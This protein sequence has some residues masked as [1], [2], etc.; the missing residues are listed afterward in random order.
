MPFEIQADAQ[1]IRTIFTGK[2]TETE[3]D[4]LAREIARIEGEYKIGP[5]RLVDFSAIEKSEV[6]S[7]SIEQ[8]AKAGRERVYPNKFRSAIVAQRLVD[9]GCARMYQT[10]NDNPQ[11]E[12][13]VFKTRAEAEAWLAGGAQ[14][15]FNHG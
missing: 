2:V 8:R 14:K 4:D 9:Y 11:I 1:T 7:A 12:I 15:N 10:Y 3:I 13:R 6:T 5:D